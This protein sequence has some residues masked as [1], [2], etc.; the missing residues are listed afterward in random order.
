[1]IKKFQDSG[2]RPDVYRMY[3]RS[4]P[5]TDLEKAYALTSIFPIRKPKLKSDQDKVRFSLG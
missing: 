4:H 5:G 2:M 3:V 1:M